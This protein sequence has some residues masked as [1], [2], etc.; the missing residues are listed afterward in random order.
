MKRT[1][2]L[3]LALALLAALLIALPLFLGVVM[4]ASPD[5]KN[6]AMQ[7]G[8]EITVVLLCA[9]VAAAG[10]LLEKRTIKDNRDLRAGVRTVTVMTLLCALCWS[11]LPVGLYSTKTIFRFADATET[12]AALP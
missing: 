9:A 11:R 1:L 8:F 3:T 6:P 2:L 10:D 4:Q 5:G 12:I 7:Y